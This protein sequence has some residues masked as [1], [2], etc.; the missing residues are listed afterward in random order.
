[1]AAQLIYRGIP[2]N[3]LWRWGHKVIT[4]PTRAAELWRQGHDIVRVIESDAEESDG[5][6]G[7]SRSP[8]KW[9]CVGTADGGHKETRDGVHK[10]K[11][12]RLE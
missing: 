4:D 12:Q 6:R 5:E 3:E 2:T 8:V 11:K 1:M 7:R 10:Q 9:P